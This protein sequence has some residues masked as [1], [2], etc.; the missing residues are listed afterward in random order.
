[1]SVSVI[2]TRRPRPKPALPGRPKDLG[3]GAAILQAAKRMFTAHGFDG[4][5]MDQIAAAAGVSKLTVYSH[6]GDK[7]ALFVAAVR[8]KCEEQM[9]PELFLAERKG[10]LR[11]QLTRIARAFFA[12]VTSDEALSMHRMML[13]QSSDAHV[14]QMF[15]QAG[16]QRVQDAFA[17]FLEAR[18]ASGDLAVGDIRRAASQFFCLLKGELHMRMASGLCGQPGKAE[19]DAHIAAT[20]DLFLRAYGSDPRNARPAAGNPAVRTAVTRVAVTKGT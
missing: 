20:V 15:W 4:V 9:P 12:L 6:F 18:I 1:M 11:P 5:S 14:R 16:P 10:P 2:P 17:Q 13:T 7:E 19:V 3:K 8:A